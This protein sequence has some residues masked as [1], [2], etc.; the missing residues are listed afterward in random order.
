MAMTTCRRPALLVVAL[1]CAAGTS[2]TSTQA[3][4]AVVQ[5]Y[6]FDSLCPAVD[7][8]DDY[9]AE[10]ANLE[11]GGAAGRE[12]RTQVRATLFGIGSSEGRGCLRV[13]FKTPPKDKHARKKPLTMGFYV[14]SGL[15]LR[16]AAPRYVFRNVR[17]D[18]VFSVAVPVQC[19]AND[20]AACLEE[21]VLVNWDAEELEPG[22]MN[23]IP[24]VTRVP[25]RRGP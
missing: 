8:G 2:C 15:S 22:M 10:R 21:D 17:A 4:P 25:L 1:L 9:W 18:T 13:D 6:P 11:A 5:H 24:N 14:E 12:G 19:Q 7:P 20:A 16:D 23:C 3:K